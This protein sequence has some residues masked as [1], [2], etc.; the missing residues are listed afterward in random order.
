MAWD[1]AQVRSKTFIVHGILGKCSAQVPFGRSKCLIAKLYPLFCPRNPMFKQT[2]FLGVFPLALAVSLASGTAVQ[3]APMLVNV[4]LKSSSG[5][6]AYT[7]GSAVF[8]TPTSQWNT[9]ASSRN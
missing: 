7:T 8:G 1:S 2:V 3:A 9:Y 5:G 4:D 6:D